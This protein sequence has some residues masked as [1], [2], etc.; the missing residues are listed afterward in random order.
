MSHF[1]QLY[2]GSWYQ[3]E[4]FQWAYSYSQFSSQIYSLQYKSYSTLWTDE[5]GGKQILRRESVC[6]CANLHVFMCV[7]IAFNCII[8]YMLSLEWIGVW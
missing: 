2:I 8:F 7:N 5:L 4:A 3:S 1:E 6:A